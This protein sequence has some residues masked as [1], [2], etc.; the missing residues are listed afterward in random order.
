MGRLLSDNNKGYV[1]LLGVLVVGAAGLAIALG[2]ILSGTDSLRAAESIENSA[3]ARS[4]ANACAEE[5]LQEIRDTTSFEGTGSLVFADGSCL[6]EVISGAGQDRTIQASGT[7][8]SAVRKVV[9]E[10][11]SINPDI[12]VVSWEEKA[13]F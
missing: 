8:D 1:A 7:A 10:I 12:N 13:D 3:Q 9:V 5:A 6:F 2:V 11:D 4:F